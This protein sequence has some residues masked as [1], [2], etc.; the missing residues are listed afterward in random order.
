MLSGVWPRR[1]LLPQMKVPKRCL[2]VHL[3]NIHQQWILMSNLSEKGEESTLLE[4]GRSPQTCVSDHL[5]QAQ[6]FPVQ[7]VAT[8]TG[9]N[10]DVRVEH[11]ENRS[12]VQLSPRKNDIYSTP[13]GYREYPAEPGML[14]AY[15]N[16]GEAPWWIS[17]RSKS[18]LKEKWLRRSVKR[19]W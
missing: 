3:C 2:S 10:L 17:R 18:C 5:C 9:A 19:G 7:H 14:N 12:R 15:V 1:E 11:V 16:T 13:H 6:N 8:W 4:G